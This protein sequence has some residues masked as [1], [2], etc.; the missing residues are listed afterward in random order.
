MI[1]SQYDA[2]KIEISLSYSVI[3]ELLESLHVMASPNHHPITCD[4]AKRKYSVLSESLQKEITFFGEQYADFA[5]IMDVMINITGEAYPEKLTVVESL[6]RMLKMDNTEFAYIFLGLSVFDYNKEML[7]KWMKHPEKITKEELGIQSQF[8]SVESVNL[9]LKDIDGMK[10]R[11]KILIEKYWEECF[12]IEWPAIES[13]F[14]QAIKKEEIVLQRSSYLEYIENIHPNLI[15]DDG[16]IV[17]R[18]S[19]DYSVPIN[20]IRKLIVNLSVFNT[21]HLSGNMIGDTM[22]VVKN[23]N[24]HSVQMK[25]AIPQKINNVIFAA[26]DATRLRIIKILWNSDSTTKEI[27]E[28]LEL[29]PSTISL[30]LKILKEADLVET[31]KIKKFVFY[32]LKKDAFYSLQEELLSYFEY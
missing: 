32:R 11:L 8:L 22:D 15:V 18:K 5:F 12:S 13:Y 29:S 20:R 25:A 2:S 3:I 16:L 9:F 17:F 19:P 1:I 27:A 31:N 14:E 24:F 23:L 10:L 6:E 30:H 26:D 4:W 7:V 28:V 21:P